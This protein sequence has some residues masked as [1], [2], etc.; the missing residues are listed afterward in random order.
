[1]FRRNQK[2]L[3][4]MICWLS[5]TS[6]WHIRSLCNTNNIKLVL[7]NFRLKIRFLPNELKVLS[8]SR[9]VKK[10]IYGPKNKSFL[11]PLHRFTQNNEL[12]SVLA[13]KRRWINNHNRLLNNNN[14]WFIL[15]R[16]ILLAFLI[17]IFQHIKRIRLWKF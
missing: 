17:G 14:T 2:L 3:Q 4:K 16:R 13:I 5:Y 11:F 7:L 8:H 1:M 12:K 6:S 9:S 10:L 15:I